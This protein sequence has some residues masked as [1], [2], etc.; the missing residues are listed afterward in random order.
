[1]VSSLSLVLESR[2]KSEGLAPLTLNISFLDYSQITESI[3]INW[4]TSN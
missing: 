2:Q 1:M 3:P 4:N